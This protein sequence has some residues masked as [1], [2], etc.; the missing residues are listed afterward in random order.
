LGH[1]AGISQRIREIRKILGLTQQQFADDLKIS[2]AFAGALE[3]GTR[4][5]HERIIKIICFTYGINE[6]WLKTGNGTMFEEGKDYKLEEA[7]HNFKKLD[8]LLQDYVLKQIRLALEYQE[9]KNTE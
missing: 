4:K 6:D 7:I 8:S 1:K 9:T 5:I 3:H 2:R